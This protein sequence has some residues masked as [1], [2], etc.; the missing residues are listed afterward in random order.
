MEAWKEISLLG[1]FSWTDGPLVQSRSLAGNEVVGDAGEGQGRSSSVV[2]EGSF[3]KGQD[4]LCVSHI[5]PI[6]LYRL[7]V[8]PPLY[9]IIMQLGSC[10]P[11]CG[12]SRLP[13]YVGRPVSCLVMPSV[14]IRQ[15]TH[16]ITFLD[17]IRL[18]DDGNC[19]F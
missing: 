12:E 9:A 6:L 1:P 5:Y 14:E 15:H 4:R 7:S 11:C 16:C 10:C 2:W 19:E 13:R 18:R 3:L 8:L 17:R